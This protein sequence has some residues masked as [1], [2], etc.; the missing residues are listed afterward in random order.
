MNGYEKLVKELLLKHGYKLIRTGKGSHEIW[1]SEKGVSVT[2]NHA[3]K[4]R[5]TANSIMKAAGIAFRF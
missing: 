4:S 1:A 5:H 3:C 2:V